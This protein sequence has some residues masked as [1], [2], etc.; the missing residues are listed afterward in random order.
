[1]SAVLDENL[2]S[3]QMGLQPLSAVYTAIERA[4]ELIL[5]R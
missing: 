4:A 5:P 1:M 2:R 3:W